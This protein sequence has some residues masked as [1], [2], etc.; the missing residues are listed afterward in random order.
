MY[1][2]PGPSATWANENPSILL[3]LILISAEN[4]LKY[5]SMTIRYFLYVMP[6]VG[7]KGKGWVEP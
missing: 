7:G 6:G 5:D 1:S 4:C 3:F 2:Q